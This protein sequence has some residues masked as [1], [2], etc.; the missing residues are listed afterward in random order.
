[1]GVHVSGGAAPGALAMELSRRAFLEACLAAAAGGPVH[2]AM[3]GGAVRRA[4]ARPPQVRQAP[5]EPVPWAALGETLRQRYRDPR[6]HF[7]FEYYPWYAI[8]PVRHWDQWRRT[9][10][11]DIAASSMP[12]LGPYDSHAA[13]VIEQHARWIADAGVGVVNLSWWGIGSYSD[14]AVPLVMD[15]MRAHDIHVT[16]H[17]EPYGPERVERTVEDLRY[18]VHEY[19]ERRGWDALFLHERTDGSTGPVFKWFRTT[20]PLT[21]VDCHGVTQDVA[22]YT[23][24]GTWRSVLYDARVEFAGT[25]DRVTLLADT[26]DVF[27]AARAGW[28]GVAVYDPTI[29]IAEW[30]GVAERA[31][32]YGLPFTFP[33]NPGL[34]MID[35]RVP[36][37]D[38]LSRVPPFVP[39]VGPLDWSSRDDRERAHA[40]AVERVQQTLGQNLLLQLDAE[41][42]N[43]EE[44]FF[45][46]Y[47]VTFN[48][49]HEGTQFEPMKPYGDLTEAERAVGYHNPASGAFARLDRLSEL[50]HRLGI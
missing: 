23:P 22:D 44:G 28:D 12:L 42:E 47:I 27:R 20:L 41:L 18:L 11:V 9:P 10:P 33:V 32:E 36:E 21:E 17:L 49:W 40:A 7:V 26:V 6:R 2:G 35:P 30:S 4:R 8:D 38:C 34:D 3:E 39:D 37:S 31:T 48:E 43:V 46:V 19:G 45:L 1:M 50:F 25:F 15:V 13:A 24:D 29:A 5:A 16:F 14:R